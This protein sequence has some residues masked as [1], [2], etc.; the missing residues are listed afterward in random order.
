MKVRVWFQKDGMGLKSKGML[1]EEGY[2]VRETDA[3]NNI[4]RASLNTLTAFPVSKAQFVQLSVKF[5]SVEIFPQNSHPQT[6]IR[7]RQIAFRLFSAAILKQ[8][9]NLLL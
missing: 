7:I 6:T 2:R 5:T 8:I 9:T 4:R 3:M 1:T